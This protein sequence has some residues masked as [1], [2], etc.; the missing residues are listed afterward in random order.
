MVLQSVKV[1][2]DRTVICTV[3]ELDDGDCVGGD[4]G[5][6]VPVDGKGCEGTGVGASVASLLDTGTTDGDA[7]GNTIG[8]EECKAV[9]FVNRPQLGRE[10]GEAVGF[11]DRS[12]LDIHEGISEG[13]AD[14][15]TVGFV[16]A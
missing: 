12:E 5:P 15:E 1:K 4:V 16:N 14:G 9:G 11:G 6:A 8:T 2:F 3:D 7:V 13:P 10:K